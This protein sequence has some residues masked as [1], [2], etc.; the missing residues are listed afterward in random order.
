M[1]PIKQDNYNENYRSVRIKADTY[2]KLK[3]LAV[4]M[5]V[6]ITRL[7]DLIHDEYTKSKPVF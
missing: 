2:K 3:L 1:K 4:E 6:P 5:E 7:I